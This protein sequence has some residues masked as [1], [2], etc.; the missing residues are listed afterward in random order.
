M[1]GKKKHESAPIATLI[2]AG[3]TVTGDLE[4]SG[5]LHL[6]GRIIGDVVGEVG[7]ASELTIGTPGVIEGTVT[8][9]NI[10]LLGT[11]NGDVSA[12]ARVELG[13]T[14]HV[15]G[16][17]AYAVL[18]MAAGARVNGRLIHQPGGRQAPPPADG[19]AAAELS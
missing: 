3:T 12:R 10:V 18:Q 2:G 7:S 5:G 1:F 19:D 17:V 4:F 8:A 11:V 14:A 16:N 15:A 13:A 6:D 9:D